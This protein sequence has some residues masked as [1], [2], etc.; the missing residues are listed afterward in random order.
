MLRLSKTEA[1]EI[2]R[3]IRSHSIDNPVF[4]MFLS[5]IADDVVVTTLTD[6]ELGLLFAKWCDEW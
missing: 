5:D 3:N 6:A 2:G 4:A 1:P